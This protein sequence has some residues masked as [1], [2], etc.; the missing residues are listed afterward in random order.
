MTTPHRRKSRG[1]RTEYVED[2][3]MEAVTAPKHWAR[4]IHKL[5]PLREVKRERG[6]HGPLP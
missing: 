2:G 5:P 6:P 3:V 1:D 4:V